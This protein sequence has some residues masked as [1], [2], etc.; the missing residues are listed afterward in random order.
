M[1]VRDYLLGGYK[2]VAA[3]T[4]Q[5]PPG[6]GA[7]GSQ[8]EM[9]KGLPRQGSLAAQ[10]LKGH[11]D[12]ERAADQTLVTIEPIAGVTLELPGDWRVVDQ[13]AIQ[14]QMTERNQT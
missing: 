14:Q 1:T 12:A 3:K 10:V 9:T 7:L 13:T 11:E 8:L 2:C 6:F 5:F 4:F